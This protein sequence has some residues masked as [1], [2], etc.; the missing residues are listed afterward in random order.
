M[1]VPI[2][3]PSHLGIHDL[4][5]WVPS[6]TNWQQ[7]TLADGLK[8]MHASPH[9]VPLSLFFS[10]FKSHVAAS[11]TPG[12]AAIH[13]GYTRKG[14]LPFAMH[15]EV[16]TLRRHRASVCFEGTAVHPFWIAW[17]GL[18]AVCT[19]QSYQDLCFSADSQPWK[20]FPQTLLGMRYS[21]CLLGQ[22]WK[23]FQ[24]LPT[25]CWYQSTF[26]TVAQWF[27]DF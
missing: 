27:W 1:Q 20:V 15:S 6:S 18:P 17:G 14:P 23:L 5:R 9:Y 22:S 4:R 16:L 7:I 26:Q 21:C 2:E 13:L 19:K 25:G 12:M 3:S 10:S 24:V 8:Y 11:P